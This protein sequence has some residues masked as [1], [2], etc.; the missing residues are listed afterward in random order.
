MTLTNIFPVGRCLTTASLLST[1]SF[2]QN[3]RMSM[4]LDRS[5]AG[6][7]RLMLEFCD[8]NSPINTTSK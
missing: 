1:F 8:F 3:S 6:P 2:T 7:P 5:E 4:C